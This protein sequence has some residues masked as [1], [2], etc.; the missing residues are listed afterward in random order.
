M[1]YFQV[2]FVHR[3]TPTTSPRAHQNRIIAP[4]LCAIAIVAGARIGQRLKQGASTQPPGNTALQSRSVQN[5]DYGQKRL[6]EHR[7]RWGCC[8]CWG[9]VGSE[10]CLRLC[11][12]ALFAFVGFPGATVRRITGGGRIFCGVTLLFRELI[13]RDEVDVALC[14]A[15]FQDAEV[16]VRLERGFGVRV[17]Y[18]DRRG[19]RV[20][21]PR[22]R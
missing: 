15:V 12:F 5:T 19:G 9:A 18:Q 3:L 21:R 16:V 11:L 17:V 8:C 7:C 22:W 20:T 10:L 2:K 14:A 1:L 13:E 6:V 4:S